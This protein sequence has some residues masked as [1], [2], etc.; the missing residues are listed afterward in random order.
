[1]ARGEIIIAGADCEG[2]IYLVDTSETNHK[3]I[4]TARD[5]K[6]YYGQCI[7]CDSKE[8]EVINNESVKK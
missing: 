2:C 1:M 7:P 3:I 6:Y 4:C 8:E 5:K